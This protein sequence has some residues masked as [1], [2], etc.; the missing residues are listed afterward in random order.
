MSWATFL[1]GKPRKS[2]PMDFY[3]KTLQLSLA[4]EMPFC[5]SKKKLTRR[6]P[7]PYTG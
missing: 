7:T 1:C 6:V 4:T 2:S 5:S 3:E